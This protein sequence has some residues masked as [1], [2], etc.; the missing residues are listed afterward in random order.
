[1]S[2]S[3]TGQYTQLNRCT[4]SVQFCSAWTRPLKADILRLISGTWNVPEDIAD[5]VHRVKKFK[6]FGF[7]VRRTVYTA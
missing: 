4:Q 1:M 2:G 5:N 7:T 3:C 6:P